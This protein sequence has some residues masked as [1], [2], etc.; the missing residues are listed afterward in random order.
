MGFV[1]NTLSSRDG[2]ET[3][4]VVIRLWK[5]L[6][7]ESLE[8]RKAKPQSHGCGSRLDAF[9][10]HRRG[11]PRPA[12]PVRGTSDTTSGRKIMG[13]GLVSRAATRI[14]FLLFTILR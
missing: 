3:S 13:W 10:R 1:G 4:K 6:V 5:V 7:T 8:A 9:L 14:F 12:V 2:T 11:S